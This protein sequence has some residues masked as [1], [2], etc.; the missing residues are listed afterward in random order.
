VNTGDLSP[1]RA[2]VA[3][4][5]IRYTSEFTSYLFKTHV[6]HVQSADRWIQPPV[7]YLKINFDGS[8]RRKLAQVAEAS[9]LGIATATSVVQVCGK[10][11]MSLILFMLKQFH[12]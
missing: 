12:V 6:E 8:F 3:S 4:S 2:A 5:A 9:A 10:L 1:V 11:L 7:N